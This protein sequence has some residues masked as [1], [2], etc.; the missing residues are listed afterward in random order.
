[1]IALTFSFLLDLSSANNFKTAYPWY[2]PAAYTLDYNLYL[3]LR[4]LAEIGYT[5]NDT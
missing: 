1:M 5:A 2:V 3:K 4:P